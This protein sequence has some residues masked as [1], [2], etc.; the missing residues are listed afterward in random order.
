[1]SK[2]PWYD[3][4]IN[5]E[6]TPAK[7]LKLVGTNKKV[8]ECGCASGYVSKVLKERFNCTV[9]GI[10]IDPDAAKEAEKYCSRVIVG[11]LEAMNFSEELGEDKFDVITF[12]DVLEHLKDPGKVLTALRVFLKDDGYIVASIPNLAHISVVLEL[13]NGNFDYRPLGLLDDT[14]LRFFTKK[15]ILSLFRN[16][17]YEIVLWDRV[18]LKPEDTEFQTVLDSCPYS[19]LSFFGSGSEL[20][21]YHFVVKAVLYTFNKDL[22]ELQKEWENIVRQ[23]LRD[24]LAEKERQR[25]ELAEKFTEKERQLKAVY[26]SW[27]WRITVPLRWLKHKIL[28]KQRK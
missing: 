14:H 9:T 23:E 27:S 26:S 3:I 21:T 20:L 4:D 18:I 2:Y 28:R 10:E 5:S 22:T 12:G 15:S 8:L 11:D 6:T 19:L 24:R 13:L 7:L 16:A 25:R 17:G 1:M